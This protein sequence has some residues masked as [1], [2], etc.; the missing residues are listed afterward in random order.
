MEIGKFIDNVL[1]EVCLD[2]RIK[3]GIFDIQNEYH[4]SILRQYLVEQVDVEFA[5]TLIQE[6]KNIDL[7]EGNFPERQ[8]Y[9]KD[10]VLVTFP[11]AESKKA[12]IE[13]K[14]HF[15]NDPTGGA[16]E[17]DTQDAPEMDDEEEEAEDMFNDYESAEEKIHK[18]EHSVSFPFNDETDFEFKER[19]QN[20]DP[21]KD[22][23]HVYDVLTSIKD[24]IVALKTADSFNKETSIIDWDQLH[25]SILFA[26]KQKWEYDKG[27]NWY[28]ELNHF[29]ASTDRRGQLDP[30]KSEDKEEMLLWMD[31][32][33]K[34][35]K[36]TVGKQV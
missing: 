27:G 28:D 6:I 29:R 24:D 10:G 9:N 34:R 16:G 36:S 17:A 4:I 20:E 25:P 2:A 11:D 14:S 31:D 12:A 19:E 21:A 23:H 1:S 15:E 5:T 18:K 8:A 7:D 22:V 30:A 26:L 35:K 13:R 32:Y 3:N 33:L